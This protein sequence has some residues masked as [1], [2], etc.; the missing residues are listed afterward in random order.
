MPLINLS[1]IYLVPS[2]VITH[3]TKLPS[4]AWLIVML[5]CFAGALNYLD[6]NVITTMRG[7]I[8]EAMPMNDAQFGLLTSVFL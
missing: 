1:Q 3:E 8:V 2:T 4:G 6:R 5:L 7:S